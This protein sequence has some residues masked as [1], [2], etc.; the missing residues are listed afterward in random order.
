MR[1]DG[2]VVP[3]RLMPVETETPAAHDP[4]GKLIPVV[5]QWHG[6]GAASHDNKAGTGRVRPAGRPLR[7]RF[8][9]V[10]CL[11]GCIEAS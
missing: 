1:A 6:D 5:D 8:R 3:L 9:Q 10:V 7:P 2:V 4:L 11:G